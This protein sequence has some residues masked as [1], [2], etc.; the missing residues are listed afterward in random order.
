MVAFALSVM[1]EVAF[2]Q[3]ALPLFEADL[4]DVIEWSF[5]MGWSA[6]GTP[7]W[8]NALLGDY[9]EAGMLVGHG[10]SYSLLGATET[11]HRQQWLTLLANEVANRKYK[12]ISEH[13]GFLGAD[14]FSFT[15]PLPM[16][17]YDQTIALG[18]RR[19]ADITAA[20]GIPVGLENLATTLSI[21]DA[22]DQGRFLREVVTPHNGFVVLDLHNLWAQA[23]NC[24]MDAQ[25]LFET[26]PVER[27]REI[28]VSGGS[29]SESKSTSR[30]I[31]RDTHDDLVPDEVLELL[32]WAMPQ[33]PA[34]E[35]V[36]YERLG[37][38]LADP[39]SHEPYRNDVRRVKDL[40]A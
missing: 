4:I 30:L 29:W 8:V 2:A 33:C 5:D 23:I 25:E 37:H 9:S 21:R 13:V 1:P 28:H 12:W 22:L 3:A 24:E 19:V 6:G 40:I 35:L 16:P 11:A 39:D 17:V 10:V 14:R 18:V 26:Y 27:V 34:L 20:A 7:D 31:R 38:T 15:A 36:V 32:T